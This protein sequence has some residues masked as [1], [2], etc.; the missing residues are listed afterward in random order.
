MEA[1]RPGPVDEV[2]EPQH[3]PLL[4]LQLLPAIAR[5]KRLPLDGR[6]LVVAVPRRADARAAGAGALQ[7][8][9]EA[10]QDPADAQLPPP[11]RRRALHFLTTHPLALPL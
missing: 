1:E 9:G 6:R 3:L 11:H 7:G 4:L 10:V 2:P 8:Q 5:H